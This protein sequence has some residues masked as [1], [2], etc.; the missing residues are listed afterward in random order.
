MEFRGGRKRKSLN[1][2]C[3][4]EPERCDSVKSDPKKAKMPN[5]E[6][7]TKTEESNPFSFED[8]KSSA[9]LQDYSNYLKQ[10]LTQQQRQNQLLMQRR[11][12]VFR[13]MVKL[14]ELYESG[15]DGIARMGDLRNVP[16][17]V[18][19]NKLYLFP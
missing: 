2:E 4:K 15:L 10:E 5:D 3:E 12:N 16:D 19:S 18:M 7:L 9:H 13:S 6:I 8:G 14:H 11:K 1:D 17:N